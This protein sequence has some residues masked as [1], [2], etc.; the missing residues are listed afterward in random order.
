MNMHINCELGLAVA[1][2]HINKEWIMRNVE[3]NYS[4]QIEGLVVSGAATI[5]EIEKGLQ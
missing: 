3:V 2:W 4:Y 1:R 5:Q